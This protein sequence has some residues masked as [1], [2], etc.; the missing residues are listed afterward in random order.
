[1]PT[2]RTHKPH[3]SQPHRSPR[4]HDHAAHLAHPTPTRPRSLSDLLDACGGE[5]PTPDVIR[6]WVATLE[7]HEVHRAVATLDLLDVARAA[8]DTGGDPA[9][10]VAGWIADHDPDPA[11]AADE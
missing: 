1:M 8:A 5:W 6:A 7:P 4:G 3:G 9:V 10:A 2:R 11:A